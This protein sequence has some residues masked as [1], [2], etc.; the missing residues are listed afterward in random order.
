MLCFLSSIFYSI[1]FAYFFHYFS[2]V[3]IS[4]FLINHSFA[5][6][7]AFCNP[8]WW[9]RLRSLH[10]F[11]Y[12]MLCYVEY[13]SL[14]VGCNLFFFEHFFLFWEFYIGLWENFVRKE[15]NTRK[16]GQPIR[17][18]FSYKSV[19]WLRHFAHDNSPP[20]VPKVRYCLPDAISVW[21]VITSINCCI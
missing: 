13:L 14:K 21:M 3:N 4:I 6:Q 11:R 8:D 7:T 9:V 16:W 18:Q 15:P 12:I 1:F 5:W 20:S 19:D 17:I 2:L 10:C